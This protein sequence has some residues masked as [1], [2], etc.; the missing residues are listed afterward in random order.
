M[1]SKPPPQVLAT[2]TRACSLRCPVL[3]F[4]LQESSTDTLIPL[5]GFS[6]IIIGKCSEDSMRT[7]S[8]SVTKERETQ[9]LRYPGKPPGSEL[10]GEG[11]R[12][13]HSDKVPK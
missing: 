5:M 12:T 7:S 4:S 1:V 9:N 2:E 8:S 10:L 6:K 3:C 13:K 11:P